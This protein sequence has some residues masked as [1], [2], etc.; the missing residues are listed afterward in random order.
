MSNWSE[1]TKFYEIAA[2]RVDTPYEEFGKNML[3]LI[4]YIRND[5]SLGNLSPS[6]AMWT[7]L[8]SSA[9][10]IQQSIHVTWEA[11]NFVVFM[12]HRQN[13]RHERHIEEAINVIRDYVQQL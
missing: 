9:N 10:K 4:Q 13:E 2:S 1:V 6:T 7:L 11:G 12:T 3:E 5:V 8:L